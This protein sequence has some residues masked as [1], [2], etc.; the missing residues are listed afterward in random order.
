MSYTPKEQ[1]LEDISEEL[2]VKLKEFREA[3]EQRIMAR[4]EWSDIHIRN[5]KIIN[6]KMFDLQ[7]GINQL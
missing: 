2:K 6:S 5:L 1:D 7:I 3:A 4:G